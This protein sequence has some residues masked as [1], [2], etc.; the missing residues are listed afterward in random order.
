[1][2]NARLTHS[3]YGHIEEAERRMML[4]IGDAV[5]AARAEMELSVD[6]CARMANVSTWQLMQLESGVWAPS[7]RTFVKVCAVLGLDGVPRSGE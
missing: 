1:M 4:S 6:Q 5:K 7:L 3:V 2:T